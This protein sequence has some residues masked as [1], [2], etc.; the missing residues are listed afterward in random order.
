[1]VTNCRNCGAP[2]DISRDACAYCDSPYVE[3]S[4]DRFDMDFYQRLFLIAAKNEILTPN[5]VRSILYAND[6]PI[7]VI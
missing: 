1:M 2:I 5:E 7:M 4:K 3:K 6:E